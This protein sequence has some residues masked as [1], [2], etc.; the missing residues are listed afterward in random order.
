MMTLMMASAIATAAEPARCRSKAER[1]RAEPQRTPR[2]R[3][4]NEMPNARPTL[5]VH[6]QMDGCTVL[7][8]KERGHI[9]EE[10]VG[11]PERRRVFRP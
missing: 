11:R 2:T 6:R 3:P 1:A 9:I 10:P 5:T 7:L 8:I 4:L